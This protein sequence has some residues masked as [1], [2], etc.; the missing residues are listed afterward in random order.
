LY[1][2]GLSCEPGIHRGEGDVS[3]RVDRTRRGTR[4]AEMAGKVNNHTKLKEEK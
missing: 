1:L 3:H 2:P 4:F